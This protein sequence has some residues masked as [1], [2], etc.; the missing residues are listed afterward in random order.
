LVFSL[1]FPTFYLF[2]TQKDLERFH[3]YRHGETEPGRF[4]ISLR[5]LHGGDSVGLN[6]LPFTLS[7]QGAYQTLRTFATPAIQLVEAVSPTMMAREL[8]GV[9]IIISCWLDGPDSNLTFVFQYPCMAKH[10]YKQNTRGACLL[11]HHHHSSRI[12]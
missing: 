6:Y 8:D 3:I 1:G 12:I 11:L 5:I 7:W 2:N 9:A 10:T 4:L